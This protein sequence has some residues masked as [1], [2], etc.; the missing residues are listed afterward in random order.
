MAVDSHK[1]LTFPSKFVPLIRL[2][3]SGRYCLESCIY[4]SCANT[5]SAERGIVMVTGL[6]G[7]STRAEVLIKLITPPS[8][9]DVQQELT[10]KCKN[11][12]FELRYVL[13][14]HIVK[15]RSHSYQHSPLCTMQ[16]LFK[17][18][19]CIVSYLAQQILCS[20][21]TMLC[22][23]LCIRTVIGLVATSEAFLLKSM[24]LRTGPC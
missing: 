22:T 12:L 20:S 8:V 9:A 3:D 23:Q 17:V 21:F 18:A 13:K 24:M 19:D 11:V 5:A 14:I 7:F 2:T 15:S 4:Q 6:Q 16:R 1:W 10:F